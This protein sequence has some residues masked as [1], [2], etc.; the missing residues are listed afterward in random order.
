MPT[1]GSLGARKG[2]ELFTPALLLMMHRER[3]ARRVVCKVV[4]HVQSTTDDEYLPRLLFCK[5][6]ASI[7]Q[8]L[9][10]GVAKGP[11][12]YCKAGNGRR[13]PTR[14]GWRDGGSNAAAPCHTFHLCCSP[15]L[16]L[17]GSMQHNYFIS[18]LCLTRCEV[19]RLGTRYISQCKLLCHLV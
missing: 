11:G 19:T 14:N 13:P 12:G 18:F 6:C 16:N 9:A 1:A 3:A 4:I 2:G 7:L 10:T 15:S 17:D 8:R 5:K